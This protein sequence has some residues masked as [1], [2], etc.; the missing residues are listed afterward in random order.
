MTVFNDCP[1][2]IT[3]IIDNNDNMSEDF[4]SPSIIASGGNASGCVDAST[5]PGQ[6][7]F[8]MSFHSGDKMHILLG[9]SPLYATCTIPEYLPNGKGGVVLAPGRPSQTGGDYNF[10][11]FNGPG[12][13]TPLINSV[14]QANL[15][16]II[17]Y[18]SSNSINVKISETNSLTIKGLQLDPASVQCTYAGILPKSGGSSNLWNV[19]MVFRLR[20][21]YLVGTETISD[22][23]G[24][25]NLSVTD[26]VV[27]I[28]AQIDLTFH[29]KPHVTAL[30]CSLGDY[31]LSGTIID[32]LEALFPLIE[33]LFS[34]GATPFRVAGFINTIFNASVISVINSFISKVVET[35]HPKTK[36]ASSL[37]HSLR[38][39]SSVLAY[40]RRKVVKLSRP[41][42]G[43]DLSIWM[44]TPQIQ[45]RRMGRLKL[46]GT[47]SSATYGLTAVL[48]QIVYPH[49][50]F[51]WNMSAHAS[52]ANGNWPI[53]IPPERKNPLY[54]GPICHN[55][56]LGRAVNAISRT[57]GRNI[58]EQLQSGIRHFDFRVYYDTR[59]GHFYTQHILRGPLFSD[60]LAQ[61]RFFINAHPGSGELIF[62]AISHTN[63]GHHPA[64]APRF[65]Q[66]VNSYIAPE[67][68]YYEPD[69]FGQPS[70]DFQILSEATVADI[71]QGA[72]K[73]MFMN[74][75]WRVYAFA[76]VITNTDG[77]AGAPI[78]PGDEPRTVDDLSAQQGL[79]L[80]C[81]H[82]DSAPLWSVDW[83]L[84]PDLPTVVQTVL[85]HLTGVQKWALQDMAAQANASLAGF[86][87]LHG[88]ANA[89]FNVVSV[90][91]LEYGA[92][93]SVSELVIG[94]NH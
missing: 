43:T 94:M 11:F 53:C 73:V 32:V 42:L 91:W 78:R 24:S 12:V 5:W 93:K 35:P 33:N 48:S 29:T 66:L 89:R 41:P 27:Y 88:G 49:V 44:S 10:W 92:E 25:F 51:L 4:A 70:F 1:Q 50:Q 64:Q 68:L 85:I 46:P 7:S 21:G 45:A 37:I 75:D 84:T 31:H 17:K 36:Y 23:T 40:P 65:A 22:Q 54:I 20:E 38:F 79:G 14:M 57:Q 26:L 81:H 47:H 30:Q 60:V 72:P 6:S 62:A 8:D 71:T 59:D 56:I 28:Q 16:A 52:P 76:D 13:L 69:S 74:L 58:L 19:N 87:N 86:L 63:F 82:P 2:H 80:R 9:Q 77:Y 90:D 67:Y 18:I 15:P 83:V 3:V 39:G 34:I 55:F 61:I